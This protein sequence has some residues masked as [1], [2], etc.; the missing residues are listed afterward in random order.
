MKNKVFRYLLIIL[1]LFPFY[2][3]GQQK[4][5]LQK[6]N[7]KG[8]IKSIKETIFSAIVK[9]GEIIKGEIID[10]PELMTFYTV[11]H[12]PAEKGFEYGELNCLRDKLMEQN[13]RL[14]FNNKGKLIEHLL[15]YQNKFFIKCSYKY[16]NNYQLIESQ[17][18]DYD[19][20]KLNIRTSY[21]YDVKNNSIKAIS[22]LEPGSYFKLVYKFDN[23]GNL[24]EKRG[25]LPNANSNYNYLWN[26]KYDNNNKIIR[27]ETSEGYIVT[28]NYDEK[29]FMN[30]EIVNNRNGEFSFFY[31]CNLKNDII[32]VK[33]LNMFLK[34]EYDSSDNWTKKIVYLNE[35]PERIVERQIVYYQNSK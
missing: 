18:I 31:K 15:F 33:H 12:I 3:K 16:D 10:P 28:Y 35:K 20:D 4:N 34:Y 2:S 17:F 7:L 1:I 9:S 11:L 14:I 24:L 13:N 6:L 30:E 22:M 23:K 29:G 26:F 8:N 27:S 21:N 25:V 32:F 5:D 19:N